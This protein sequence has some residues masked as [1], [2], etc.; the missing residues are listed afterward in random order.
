MAPMIPANSSIP[1]VPTEEGFSFSGASLLT[2]IV[3]DMGAGLRHINRATTHSH[4]HID[5]NIQAVI[6]TA[7][8]SASV[9]EKAWRGSTR[10]PIAAAWGLS[11][12][13]L[14]LTAGD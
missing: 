12:S 14:V 13:P 7:Q 10:H 9:C 11:K 1:D 4:T 8:H 6:L 5:V 3:L 2:P